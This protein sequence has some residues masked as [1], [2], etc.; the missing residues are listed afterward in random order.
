MHP[1]PSLHNPCG[2]VLVRIAEQLAVCCSKR[3]SNAYSEDLRQRIVRAVEGGMSQPDAARTFSV[4]LRTVQRYRHQWRATGTL[5]ARRST[6][7]TPAIPP[8]QYPALVAHLVAAPDA[9]LADHCGM[10][11]RE[12]G[13]RVS[14][15][16]MCRAQ[17]RVGW[18]HKKSRSSPANGTR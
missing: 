6:G 2:Q 10:W 3:M 17:R 4:G 8:V 15:S 16:T 11:E 18:T 7:D 5:A 14:V 13:V 1:F 9:R 12:Q